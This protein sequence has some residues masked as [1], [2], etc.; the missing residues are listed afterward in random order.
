V[1]WQLC[2]PRPECIRL[3]RCWRDRPTGG[4]PGPTPVPQRRHDDRRHPASGWGGRRGGPITTPDG[5][6]LGAVVVNADLTA[7]RDAEGR[8]RRSEER[9]R[10]VVESMVDCVFETGPAQ[11][12]LGDLVTFRLGLDGP[13]S[14]AAHVVR[15]DVVGPTGQVVPGAS[16]TVRVPPGG[17]LWHLPL[18]LGDMP[19]HWQV[20]ATDVV[21]GG[22]AFATIEVADA[23]AKLLG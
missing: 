5:R 9:H 23:P 4:G 18:A 22:A 8:L 10:R 12:A 3:W 15:L 21:S 13:A 11:A 1:K 2:W 19:G 6:K 17:N 16:G 14:A 20:R 7:F